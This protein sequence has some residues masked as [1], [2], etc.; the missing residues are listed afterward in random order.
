MGSGA[1][2]PTRLIGVAVN[3]LWAMLP[4]TPQKAIFNQ[5]QHSAEGFQGGWPQ[6]AIAEFNS[7]QPYDT[8]DSTIDLPDGFTLL[9][10][11][12]ISYQ[13]AGGDIGAGGEY[14][15]ELYDVNREQWFFEKITKRGTRSGGGNSPLFEK[16]PYSFVPQNAQCTVRVSEQLGIASNIQVILFG[17]V[18][19]QQ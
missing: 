12:G 16:A 11:L 10:I 2:G 19:G 14:A 13:A 6:W 7:V 15:F 4:K 17:V 3:P 1:A 5:G 9:A 8:V 18:G